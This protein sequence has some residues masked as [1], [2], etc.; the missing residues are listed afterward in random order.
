MKKMDIGQWTKLQA[1]FNVRRGN[2]NNAGISYDLIWHGF[3]PRQE[4][5]NEWDFG[6]NVSDEYYRVM[7]ERKERAYSATPF[8]QD[9]LNFAKRMRL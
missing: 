9:Y 5:H 2:W 1:V 7:M 6:R 8:S 4:R 3:P